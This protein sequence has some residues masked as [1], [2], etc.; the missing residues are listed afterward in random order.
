MPRFT[1]SH[2]TGAKDGDH[3]DLFLEEANALK[4]WRLDSP[5]FQTPQAARQTKDHRGIY[6]DFEG[7]LSG[8][9]GTVKIWDTGTYLVDRWTEKHIRI[10]LVGR[11]VR[12]RLRL[13]LSEEGGGGKDPVWTALD[14]ANVIRK[15]A[16]A[17]LR[18]FSLDDAPAQELG[19]LRQAL[20]A[21]ERRILSVVDQY[22]HGAPVE[23]ARAATDPELRKRIE[24]A[25]ARWQ[26]P[27]LVSAKAF[28]DKL[29]ELTTLIAEYRPGP[30]A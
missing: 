28:A 2:H 14:A 10:A 8:G 21:E 20:A 23:W 9:R 25:R 4:S 19:D 22:T 13:D 26:H 3:Y 7:E 5:S 11:Q 30:L 27:W 18:D 24:S 17:F 6:L 12:T 1:I 15:N 16:A 29:E